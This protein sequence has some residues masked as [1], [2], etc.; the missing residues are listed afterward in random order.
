LDQQLPIEP[1]DLSQLLRGLIESYPNLHPDTAEIGLEEPRPV[2]LGSESLRRK[3]SP[4]RPE[5]PDV[6]LYTIGWYL[7]LSPTSFKNFT[8]SPACTP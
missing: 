6:L 1:V 7:S 4:G 3:L 8:P 5:S 2:V